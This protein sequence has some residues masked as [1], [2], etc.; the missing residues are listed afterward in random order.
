V[1]ATDG[2]A[3]VIDYKSGKSVGRYKLASW[4]EENQFQ[5]A[6]YALALAATGE[7]EPVGALYQPLAGED[8][9]ARGMVEAGV[10]GLGSRFFEA[11]RVERERFA[12][13][14]ERARVRIAE[15]AAR[16]RRGELGCDP[17]RCS[18]RGRCSY[19]SICRCDG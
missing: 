13:V 4:D 5:G 14:L 10:P 7:R 18:F 19:P 6:L 9:R 2:K 12:E 8:R 3:L 15:T 17:E 16:L 1:D 11:D